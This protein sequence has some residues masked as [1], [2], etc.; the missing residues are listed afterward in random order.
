MDTLPIE[1]QTEI[2]NI[3]WKGVFK[4]NVLDKFTE[5]MRS[6]HTMDSFLKNHFYSNTEKEYDVQIS[7]YL[8]QC[9]MLLN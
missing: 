4:E 9:N 8:K 7:Y 5:T 1:L 6:F 3:Y 2:W